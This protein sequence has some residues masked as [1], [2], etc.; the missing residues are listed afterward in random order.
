[1]TLNKV[2]VDIFGLTE[3]SMMETGNKE[4]V[5]GMASVLTLMVVPMKANFKIISN[6][7]EVN[8]YTKTLAN[9]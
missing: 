3:Q 1:M 9:I 8:S 6:M 7:E 4:N 5:L 2:M